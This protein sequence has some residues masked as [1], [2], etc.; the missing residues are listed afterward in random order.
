MT[1]MAAEVKAAARRAT[2][3][4]GLDHRREA[5]AASE[6]RA[7]PG[8]CRRAAA[9]SPPDAKRCAGS[10]AMLVPTASRRTGSAVERRRPTSSPVSAADN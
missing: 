5:A 8:T 1:T 7:T 6:A 4:P 9:M 2:T 3:D 10:A